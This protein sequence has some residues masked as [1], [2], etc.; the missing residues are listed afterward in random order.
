M[1]KA[2]TS[3]FLLV[4]AAL[5]SANSLRTYAD[6][7]DC[8]NL[9]ID[10]FDSVISISISE[11]NNASGV[12]VGHNQVLTVAHALPINSPVTA[13]LSSDHAASIIA[14]HE[15][16]DL[17][18]LST[19]TE[20]RLPIKLTDAELAKQQAV[21]AVGFNHK[22]QKVVSK[23][24]FL[25]TSYNGLLS[26]ARVEPGQSGGAL[27]QCTADE[28]SLSGILQSFVASYENGNLINKG[29][30][31]SVPATAIQQFLKAFQANTL[32]KH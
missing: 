27:F 32:A 24:Q 8:S 22:K 2:V 15:G 6:I 19:D 10:A 21:W 30:S 12:I 17:A 7:N 11:N 29:R 16:Y 26:T 31:S 9:S 4:I 28:V 3:H 14:V 18:L 1:Y 20:G 5:I 13:K 25:K 23:G